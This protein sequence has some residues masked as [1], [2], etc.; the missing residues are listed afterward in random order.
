MSH[1]TL[2][3]SR[4]NR[5]MNE[6]D[7]FTAALEQPRDH[8]RA[9]L[10]GA[11]DGNVQLRER[12]ERLLDLHSAPGDF[13]QK[14][15]ADVLE[16][17]IPLATQ[18]QGDSI[19]PYRLQQQI[20]EGGMGTVYMAEQTEPVQRKV[21][22]KLIKPGMDSRQVIRSSG[23]RVGESAAQAFSECHAGHVNG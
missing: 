5:I 11:C 3:R 14:P 6:L 7:I 22:L 9:F 12:I 8:R 2:A 15:A 13:F 17:E 23:F 1:W 16:T 19:G 20:G 21:A 10:D 18:K 4:G